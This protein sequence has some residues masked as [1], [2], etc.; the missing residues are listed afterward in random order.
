MK[1]CSWASVTFRPS[2]AT[3]LRTASFLLIL[4]VSELFFFSV[5]IDLAWL[6]PKRNFPLLLPQIAQTHR[7]GKRGRRYCRQSLSSHPSP[8][9]Q[10][11]LRLGT[12]LRP[13]HPRRA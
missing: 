10:T 9:A 12:E 5:M 7:S 11:D 8:T 6:G 4:A 1:A 3:A 13:S 2:S